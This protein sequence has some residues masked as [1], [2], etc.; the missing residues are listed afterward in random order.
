V[1]AEVATDTVFRSVRVNGMAYSYDYDALGRRRAKVYPAGVRDEFF[2]DMSNHLL[3]DQ[4]AGAVAPPV[5]W[6]VED[7]SVWDR[8]VALVRGRFST[9]WV[10][11][12]DSSAECARNGEE[13]A[14]GV[15]FPVTDHL[16]K[17]VL[18][19][20][21]A[22][23]VVG[24]GD[25]DP[26]GQVNRQ[27]VAR[28]TAHPYASNTRA[29]LATC[30]QAMGGTVHPSTQVRMRALLGP[31]ESFDTS[32]R[33]DDSRGGTLL[34][35]DWQGAGARSI[36]DDGSECNSYAIARAC[37][38]VKDFPGSIMGGGIR[39]WDPGN[40]DGKTLVGA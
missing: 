3:S 30:W 24:V 1:S 13:A 26:F 11:A 18:M 5:G 16:P 40:M 8:P 39:A 19:L 35:H 25:D 17:P 29:T 32:G 2:Y 4:G 33:H 12:S 22:R 14:C 23:R 21:G 15:Y 36:G 37:K 7:D 6:L 27:T 31:D 38:Q 28:G 10:R 9:E 34:Q 20:D